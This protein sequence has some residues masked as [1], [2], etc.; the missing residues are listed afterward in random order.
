[1][2]HLVHEH[3]ISLKDDACNGKISHIKHIA[4]YLPDPTRLAMLYETKLLSRFVYL[5]TG[6]IN[7][8]YQVCYN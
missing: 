1:M 7:G 6:V 8:L 2:F 5:C 4:L 3:Y